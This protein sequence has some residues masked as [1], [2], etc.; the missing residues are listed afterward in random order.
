VCVAS[1]WTALLLVGGSS[2]SLSSSSSSSLN[3][4]GATLRSLRLTLLTLGVGLLIGSAIGVTLP[5]GIH[6]LYS[7]PHD[8]SFMTPRSTSMHPAPT[9]NGQHPPDGLPDPNDRSWEADLARFKRMPKHKRDQGQEHDH[10]HDHD[11]SSPPT[12]PLTGHA[13]QDEHSPIDNHS[14]N[15]GASTTSQPRPRRQLLHAGTL[16]EFGHSLISAQIEPAAA[17]IKSLTPAAP[18]KNVVAEAAATHNPLTPKDAHDHV[19]ETGDDHSFQ[20]SSSIFCFDESHGSRLM[21]AAMAIGFV[22]MLL[23]E[24][25]TGMFNERNEYY[26][27]HL[28]GVIQP[29]FN[30]VVTR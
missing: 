21:G 16:E 28:C 7:T 29:S 18:T 23:I 30:H 9:P 10:D 11:A 24:R 25:C 19:G 1:S 14:P 17:T 5:K 27:R 13:Q 22:C 6:T 20:Q 2:S 3:G 8:A 4:S 26:L 15:S 12:A